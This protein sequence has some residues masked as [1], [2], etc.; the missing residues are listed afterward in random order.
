LSDKMSRKKNHRIALTDKFS[1]IAAHHWQE[2]TDTF[3]FSNCVAKI[4]AENA[5]R[6]FFQ[7]LQSLFSGYYVKIWIMCERWGSKPIKN[8]LV[9][10]SRF[11]KFHSAYSRGQGMG[12]EFNNFAISKFIFEKKLGYE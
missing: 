3:H 10:R 1:I 7:H 8:K 11:Y 12:F 4:K 6:H 9:C 5:E 2:H